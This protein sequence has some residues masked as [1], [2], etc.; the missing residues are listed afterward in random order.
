M[1]IPRLRSYLSTTCL[2][3]FQNEEANP[4]LTDVHYRIGL[5]A[6]KQ[7]LSH[8]RFCGEGVKRRLFLWC[9]CSYA[10]ELR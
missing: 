6:S 5:H 10:S 1:S 9:S 8:P 7:T 2:F 4:L 3:I